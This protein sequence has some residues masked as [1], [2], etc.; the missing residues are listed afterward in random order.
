MSKDNSIKAIMEKDKDYYRNVHNFQKR[1][2]P[3]TFF[4]YGYIYGT[5]AK[6]VFEFGCNVGRH[7]D[8]MRQLGLEVNGID[9]VKRFI[10][11]GQKFYDLGKRIK[12][13]DEESLIRIPTNHYDVCMTASVLNHICDINDI[14]KELKRIAKHEIVI[15][16]SNN[17]TEGKSPWYPHDYEALGFKKIRKH[18]SNVKSDAIYYVYS[19][20]KRS[21]E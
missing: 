17:K 2:N 10:Q 3:E 13:G 20:K 15:C 19:W 9:P 21:E 1:L 6:S 12:V 7:L 4:V 14:V 11:E 8:Q 5:G 16:E 18:Q